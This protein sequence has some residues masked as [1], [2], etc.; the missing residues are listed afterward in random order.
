[1]ERVASVSR[2]AL[3]VG[4][5]SSGDR[6]A[7]DRAFAALEAR[8]FESRDGSPPWL[9]VRIR[10]SGSDLYAASRLGWARQYRAAS[11]AEL[12]G[13]IAA[14]PG[15]SPAPSKE[16]VPGVDPTGLPEPF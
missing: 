5:W 12:V 4:N 6:L 8:S 14:A 2:F 16:S 15:P 7:L 1:M 11:V 13:R 10:V 9:C 3:Y